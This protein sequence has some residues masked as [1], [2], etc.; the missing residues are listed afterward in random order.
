MRKDQC[1]KVQRLLQC[2]EQILE[3]R[4]SENYDYI[5]IMMANL[6]AREYQH[7]C[8]PEVMWQSRQPNKFWGKFYAVQQFHWKNAEYFLVASVWSCS[9]SLCQIFRWKIAWKIT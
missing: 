5:L 3:T 1:Q 9:F 7:T 6:H 2:K 4:E 8:R